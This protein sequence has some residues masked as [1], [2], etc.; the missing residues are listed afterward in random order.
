M[1]RPEPGDR[2]RRGPGRPPEDAQP[3]AREALLDA[4]ARLFA[5]RGFG[6]VSL[7]RI[8][9][10]AGV[11]AAMVHYYFG[12]KAGLHQAMLERA[13]DRVIARVREAIAADPPAGESP[14]AGVLQVLVQTVSA[15]PWIPPLLVREVLSEGGRLRE[16]FIRDYASVMAELLPGL[17]Q[18]EVDAGHFRDDL[19]PRLAFLSFMG[20]AVFPFVARPVVE[21]V[22]GVDYDDAFVR[23]LAAHSERLFLE[24]VRA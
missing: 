8:A 24:G 3:D 9:Q 22:L 17:L 4:A 10:E 1:V 20:M 14:L 12:D 6:E 2:P 23:R 19:D 13:F 7:R 16:R 11:S 21:R 15:E 5:H 18:R